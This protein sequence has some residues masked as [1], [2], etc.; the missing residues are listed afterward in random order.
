MD[1][2][3]EAEPIRSG[4]ASDISADDVEAEPI[5]WLNEPF[6]PFGCLVIL[7]GD[8]GQGKSVITTGMVAR[9]AS[10]RVVLPFGVGADIGPIP[11]G[12]I[13]AEDDISHAVVPRLLAAGYVRNRNV[14]FMGLKK[15]RKG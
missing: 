14:W 7:D 8:P 6:L 11:C 5:E 3:R 9:A 10:G 4:G 13:G 1:G 2:I 15:D 12:M